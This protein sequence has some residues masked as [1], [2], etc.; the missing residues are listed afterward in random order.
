MFQTKHFTDTNSFNA[1]RTP[2]SIY[3]CS[4]F[5]YEKIEAQK[6]YVSVPMLQK[7]QESEPELKLR[8]L[9]L[10]YHNI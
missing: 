5:I 4:H 2:K 1:I 3:Y 8:Y 9:A 7:F 10:N 6:Y